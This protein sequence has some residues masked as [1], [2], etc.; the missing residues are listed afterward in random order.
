MKIDERSRVSIK[1]IFIIT[2]NVLNLRF[3]EKKATHMLAIII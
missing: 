2:V 1:I 3:I